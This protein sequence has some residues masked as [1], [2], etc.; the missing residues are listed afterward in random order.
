M[1]GVTI[2][3]LFFTVCVGM[4]ID[5][6]EE[7]H[8]HDTICIFKFPFRSMFFYRTVEWS[9]VASYKAILSDDAH[10]MLLFF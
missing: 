8:N 5:F 10:Y 7:F 4:Y 2:C 3:V 6:D 9:S 1:N